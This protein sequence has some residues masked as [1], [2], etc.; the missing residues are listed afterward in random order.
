MRASAVINHVR[1]LLGDPDGDYHSDDKML[2]HLNSALED[3]IDRSRSLRVTS[4]HRL[5]V[6]QAMY[7]L[8]EAFLEA[9]IVGILHEGRWKELQYADL[10]PTL[11]AIVDDFTTGLAPWRYTIWGNAHIEKA[12]GE[13]VADP[14]DGDDSGEVSFFSSAPLAG[15]L[16]GD[17]LINITDDSEGR[18]TELSQGTSQVTFENL[19]GGLDNRMEIGDRFRILSPQASRKNLI[20]SPPP[21]RSAENTSDT[22]TTAPEE[23]TLDIGFDTLGFTVSATNDD[24]ISEATIV[25]DNLKQG[26]TIKLTGT[27]LLMPGPGFL[28]TSGEIR[29]KIV[30][31]DENE[32]AE[33]YEVTTSTLIALDLR[34]KADAS[35]I[36]IS[37]DTLETNLGLDSI[38]RLEDIRLTRTA[39]D[40]SVLQPLT[41][42]VGTESLFLYY[43]RSHK[44][45]TQTEIDDGN[46]ELEIDNEFRSTLRHRIAYYASLDEKGL[47]HPATQGFDIKY[48]TDYARAIIPVRRRIRQFISSWR[49][50]VRRNRTVRGT[51]VINRNEGRWN[52]KFY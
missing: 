18:V 13:V 9:D 14:N 15:V 28:N 31:S 20:I 22:E 35:S 44:E 10:G 27:L 17:R 25:A 38:I 26:S 41:E 1:T 43:S 8:P 49:E 24:N 36:N 40:T 30:E 48:E 29:V 21:R 42:E 4:Y 3:I 23:E 34:L 16:P 6:G 50:G 39:Q 37:I 52:L 33:T 12:I 7:G 2:L 51:E 46:D 5:I 47:D 45:I 11:P 32:V 19:D